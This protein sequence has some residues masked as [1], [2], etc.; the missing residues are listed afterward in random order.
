MA[1]NTTKATSHKARNILAE[2]SSN[3]FN[4]ASSK[5]VRGQKDPG[6]RGV[7]ADT[8]IWY[9]YSAIMWPT[10]V[11]YNNMLQRLD[12]AVNIFSMHEII[13]EMDVL[14]NHLTSDTL[15]IYMCIQI[16]A[17]DECPNGLADDNMP[18]KFHKKEWDQLKPDVLFNYRQTTDSLMGDMD[19]VDYW[20]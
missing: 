12:H 2:Y 18:I 16:R 6:S 8:L 5:K 10:G 20:C 9:I 13:S 7:I 14:H 3:Q 15:S 11:P 17:K 1:A 4:Q 19:T